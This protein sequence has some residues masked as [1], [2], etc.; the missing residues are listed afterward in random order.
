ME[1]LHKIPPVRQ[2]RKTK[3]YKVVSI[4]F[5][6]NFCQWRSADLEEGVASVELKHDAA[7]APEVTRVCPAQ[8]CRGEAQLITHNT[9]I[10][11]TVVHGFVF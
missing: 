11:K 7:H 5:F 10:P 3:A 6:A 1:L 4:I 2:K 9:T 8:F